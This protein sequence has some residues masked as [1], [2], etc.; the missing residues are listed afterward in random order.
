MQR[1]PTRFVYERDPQSGL[2][3]HTKG[4]FGPRKRGELPLRE[5]L[6]HGQHCWSVNG[7]IAL[8]GFLLECLKA[9]PTGDL[10]QFLFHPELVVLVTGFLSLPWMQRHVGKGVDVAE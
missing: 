2:T 3:P 10:S 7:K 5:W 9:L 1:A 8:P 6:Q 4:D